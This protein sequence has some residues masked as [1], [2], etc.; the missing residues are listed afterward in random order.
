MRQV[1][2]WTVGLLA[3]ISVSGHCLADSGVIAIS[4]VRGKVLVNSGD[5]YVAARAGM[6]VNEGDS[7]M[8][9]VE[10][11]AT[12]VYGESGCELAL[13]PASLTTISALNPCDL[14]IIPASNG[15]SSLAAS[16]YTWIALGG[17][18][19]VG[20]VV[21]KIATFKED[22]PKPAVSVR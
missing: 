7:V 13:K 22:D 9:G 11:A 10:G 8:V 17:A 19:L 5:G 1:W 6:P 4:Q 16:P 21:Y 2:R 3:L 14:K 20:V 18:V 12:I 15:A